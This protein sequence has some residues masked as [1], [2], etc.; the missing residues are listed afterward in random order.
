MSRTFETILFEIETSDSNPGNVV[1]TILED[2]AAAQGYSFEVVAC[3]EDSMGVEAA[4]K[5]VKT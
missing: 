1:E 4:Y 5:L 2:G 3:S